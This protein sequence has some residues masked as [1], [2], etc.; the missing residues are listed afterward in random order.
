MLNIIITLIFHLMDKQKLNKLKESLP[1]GSLA[2]AARKFHITPGAVSQI[3]S[4]SSENVEVIAYLI[5]RAKAY[6]KAL[7]SIEKEMEAL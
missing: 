3:I 4:G 7:V 1:F 2:D 6:R 5:E